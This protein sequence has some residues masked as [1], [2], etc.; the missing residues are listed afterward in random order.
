MGDDVYERAGEVLDLWRD[1]GVLVYEDKP[2]IYVYEMEF[3]AYNKRKRVKGLIA[4]VKVEEFS[5]GVILPHEFTLSK[6]KEDRLNLMKATN[7]NFSQIYA[8]YMDSEHTTLQTT[9]RMRSPTTTTS[10]TVCGSSPTKRSSK[11][12]APTLPTASSISPTVTIAT[13]PP[14]TIATTAAKTAFPRRATGRIIR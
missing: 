4:R 14:S 8:L 9:R 3:N 11:S 2:A 10:P 7:C 1:K 5:K 12:S 6:A 13:K